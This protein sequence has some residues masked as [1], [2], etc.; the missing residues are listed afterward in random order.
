MMPIDPSQENCVVRAATPK[1]IYTHKGTLL[2]R[3]ASY[4]FKVP[5]KFYN[6]VWMLWNKNP[7]HWTEQVKYKDPYLY[8]FDSFFVTFQLTTHPGVM[9]AI[10]QHHRN[11]TSLFH[12]SRSMDRVI[13]IVNEVFPKEFNEV[14]HKDIEAEDCLLTCS[15]ESTKIYRHALNK[16]L[17]AYP[18][19]DLQSTL[20]EMSRK[21]LKKWN[22]EVIRNGEINIT[23]ATQMFA[24]R[25]IS[26]LFLGLK[27]ENDAAG[28]YEPYI[29]KENQISL[30]ELA[31]AVDFINYV[32]VRTITH[33]LNK[34]EKKRYDE[35][36][37]IF[38]AAVDKMLAS[39]EKS[40][41]KNNMENLSLTQK[42]VMAF[43]LFFA[44]QE[45]TASLLN[46]ILWELA[47]SKNLQDR[48][49]QDILELEENPQAG[50]SV[51]DSI[52][53]LFYKGFIQSPSAWGIGRRAESDLIVE[54]ENNSTKEKTKRFISQGESVSPMLYHAA[55]KAIKEGKEGI[56]SKDKISELCF[57]GYGPHLCPGEKLAT[58]E[59][60][61]YIYE[62][63]KNYRFE[64]EQKDPIEHIGQTTLKRK[65]E[66]KI[67]ITPR[68]KKA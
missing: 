48:I 30:E 55:Q 22:D 26:T 10:L 3:I 53:N 42:R 21:T 2:W 33:S 15:K 59:I 51:P 58:T 50:K 44:G 17:T 6:S 32:I 38:R 62:I 8:K 37:K 43:V 14:F 63:V 66:I 47:K 40:P 24:S 39:N 12:H 67:A 49:Y 64:T 16:M 35:A 4:P 45:T 36:I 46:D 5:T 23:Q 56:Y 57:F 29:E 1:E 34:E 25:V 11:E 68:E 9:K 28:C 7:L 61:M 41:F 20:R 27:E 65:E 60:M 18:M 13:K 52:E 31:K 19:K 54:I